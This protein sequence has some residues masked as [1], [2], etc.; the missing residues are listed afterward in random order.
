[1]INQTIIKNFIF[2]LTLLLGVSAV[3]AAVNVIDV[4]FTENVYESVTYDPLTAGSGNFFDAGE[5][6]V[7]SPTGSIVITNN[8]ATDGVN[9]IILNISGYS[10]IYNLTF[11]SGRPST[12]IVSGDNVIITIP[13][14]GASQTVTYTYNI[15]E[16]NIAP[17]LNMTSSYSKSRIL[18]GLPITVTD[19]L[20]NVMNA[21]LYPATTCIYNINIVQDTGSIIEGSSIYNFTINASTVAGLDSTNVTVAPSNQSLTWNVLNS[22]CLD[23]T[24][25]TNIN[26]AINTPTQTPASDTYTIVNSTINYRTN[27]TASRLGLVSTKAVVDQEINFDKYTTNII[28]D[29]NATWEILSTV[30]SLSDIT[31][32]LTQV[33]LWV[34]VRNG[35]GTGFTNPSLID[36][37]TI[38][39]TTLLKTLTPNQLLNSSLTPWSN[40]GTEWSFNYTYASSPIVWMDIENQ[41]VS[42]GIQLTDSEVS[43]GA[44]SVYI[45]QLYVTTGYWLE[46]NKNIT[47]LADNNY[48]IFIEVKNLGNSRTPGGQAVIVYNF[49]PIAFNLTSAFVSSTSTWYQTD[50]TNTSLAD[51]T[52]NGTMYQFAITETNVYN[53]S[54]DIWG[55]ASNVNNTWSVLYNVT[56]DGEFAF[57]DLFLT[58]VDPLHIDE[59]G[60]TQA[61]SVENAYKILSA[62]GEYLLMGLAAIVGVALLLI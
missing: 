28:D 58:G 21:T 3:S 2:V 47:R 26:Y 30:T 7:Y 4:T 19:N 6:Q 38:S 53:S 27:A 12:F 62:K 29:S 42:D 5:T 45:K 8:H 22:G 44:N 10:N 40:L 59:I 51:P 34:S 24:N 9:D 17:P 50:E 60:G 15:N 11:S 31:V 46:I 61:L 52:Y 32:N 33:T 1:M 48:S 18:A 36:N 37:D 54:L 20:K 25:T 39:A 14:L 16:T 55:G 43:Y 13:D 57:E 35:T 56:G 41:I 23:S 49:L